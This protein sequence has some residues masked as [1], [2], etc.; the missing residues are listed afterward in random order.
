MVIRKQARTT[1]EA[2]LVPSGSAPICATFMGSM[3][4]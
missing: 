2:S 4:A 1:T 3:L